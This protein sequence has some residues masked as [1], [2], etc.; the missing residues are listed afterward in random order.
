M[1][2]A[3]SAL[4]PS[5]DLQEIRSRILSLRTEVL[6]HQQAY[7]MLDAPV[8]SDA[9]YDALVRELEGLESRYP[10]LAP[11]TSP[12]DQVGFAPKREFSEVRHRVPML[13]LNNAFGDEEVRQFVSRLAQ[14]LGL[15]AEALRF[16]AELKFDGIAVSLRYEQGRLIEAATRGDGSVGEDITPNIRVIQDIP[17]QLAGHNIPQV[18]EVRGEVLMRRQDF[19]ALNARQAARGEKVFVNPRNAAAGSL[20]QLDSKITAERPLSFY[21]YGTGEV[22]WAAGKEKQLST[23]SEWLDALAGWGLPVASDRAAA[24]P[25][26]GLLKFYAEI[27]SRRASLPFEID[28]V[29]Y[30]LESVAL[31][32]QAGYVSRAPRF[33][34]AHKFPAEEAS[35][36]LLG[37]DVQV[38]RTGALTPVARLEPVFVGGVTVTNATLHNVDE[39]IRKGIMIGDTVWVRR[40]G[41]VIPEVLGPIIALR[42]ADARPFVMP[43][44]CPACGT[45]AVR[46]AEE[47]VSR[48]PA[49]LTCGAQ[50]KQA[51]LHFA[52]RRAMDIEGL[53]EKIVDQLVEKNLVSTIAD[54]YGLTIDRLAALD[55][56]AEKSASNLIAQ[57]DASRSASLSRLLFGLGIRHVGE[58]T[59]RDLALHFKSLQ[60]IRDAGPEDLLQAPDVGPVVA[61][62]IREFFDNP[63]QSVIVDRLLAAIRLER[64]D[65][66]PAVAP[67]VST[68]APQPFAGMTVVLTGTLES[69]A[70]DEAANWIIALGGKT[71]GSVSAKTS[72]VIAGEAA[73]SKL[74]RAQELGVRVMDETAFLELIQPFRHQG[75]S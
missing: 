57:I 15:K 28:G 24:L 39:I 65:D 20:R 44:S 40:A 18:L 64:L 2:L 13:S 37:I 55:R 72:L 21:A 16:S 11:G 35:T 73:G 9:Q 43:T 8:I 49:G 71:S 51:F 26:E 12:V 27:L 56:M 42:P 58:R 31:Q 4:P 60:A 25:C 1:A 29:V 75:A 7:H 34:V 23:H 46:E 67:A 63:E 22:R 68:E 3:R 19:D 45:P 32:A 30:K 36:R 74:A 41:D 62:S 59:A 54:L 69:M 48:C 66:R 52:Q 47:A 10:E 14:N 70:R 17:K 61:A 33:A 6:K 5:G 50:R 53:G 38:G